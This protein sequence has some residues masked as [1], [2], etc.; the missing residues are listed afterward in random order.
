MDLEIKKIHLPNYTKFPKST[1]KN[2]KNFNI[3]Y[4]KLIPHVIYSIDKLVEMY[5]KTFP[6]EPL[7]NISFGKLKD[8]QNKFIKN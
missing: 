7:N 3:F 5:N 1:M 2:K 8:V 6:D 4:N